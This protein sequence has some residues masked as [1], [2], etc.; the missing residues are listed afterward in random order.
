MV[1]D[2]D[3]MT[4]PGIISIQ[5]GDYAET[6]DGVCGV[7]TR[8]EIVDKWSCV[9][10]R[11]NRIEVALCGDTIVSCPVSEI[12][13]RFARVGVWTSADWKKP[14]MQQKEKYFA[15][16]LK[17]WEYSFRTPQKLDKVLIFR[18]ECSLDEKTR[19]DWEK[20]ILQ[21]IEQG[22]VLLPDFIRLESVGGK[23]TGNG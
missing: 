10:K 22:V 20:C 21:G 11:V 6:V 15:S 12:P 9:S 18:T 14:P 5:E 19:E 23:E 3:M 2:L 8:V 7:V 4:K 1:F 13:E 17:P 16:T